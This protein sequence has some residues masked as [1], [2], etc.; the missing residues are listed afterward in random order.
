M[1]IGMNYPIKYAVLPLFER[2]G[3]KA[4]VDGVVPNY[5]ISAY[6]VTKCFVTEERTRYYGDG[7]Q[8]PAYKVVFPFKTYQSLNG[9]MEVPDI[10]DGECTNAWLVHEVFSGYQQAKQTCNHLNSLIT[11]SLIHQEGIAKDEVDIILE[12]ESRRLE[13]VQEFE[14]QVA[15]RTRDLSIG[16]QRFPKKEKSGC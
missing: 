6:I 14:D 1:E 7:K 3:F 9:M 10:V 12:Q 16:K 13:T 4:G 2:K 15:E 8:V 11:F 5:Q